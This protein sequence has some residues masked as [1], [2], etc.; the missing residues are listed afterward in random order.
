MTLHQSEALLSPAI[1]LVSVNQHGQLPAVLVDPIDRS[2]RIAQGTWLGGNLGD[3]T[4]GTTYA[5]VR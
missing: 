5:K 4:D 1:V 2:G 3:G